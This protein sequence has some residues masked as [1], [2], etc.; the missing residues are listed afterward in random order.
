MTNILFTIII[1]HK[2]TPDLLK[3][4]L[5]TIPVREDVETIIVDDNSDPNIVDFN[6]FPGIE[7][8]NTVVVFDKSGKGAGN[9]RNVAL[10][11]IRDTKW[12]IFSDSDDYFTDYL[13]QAMD[14]YADT[15]YDMVYF[16]RNSVYVGT[17]KPATR[18]QKAN[19]RVDY[20]LSSGDVNI[21]RYKDLAPVCKFVSYKLV[22]DNNIRF[23]SIPV[24]NDAMFFL[25]VGCRSNSIKID[26]HPIYVVTEREG[27]LMKTYNKTAIE[28]RYHTST[29][30]I[31]L[32]QKYGVERYHPNLFAYIYAFTKINKGLAFKYFFISL[33]YTPVKY[34]NRDLQACFRAFLKGNNKQI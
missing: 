34:W 3:K 26:S 33:H 22:K 10:D 13:P 1:P 25:N 6:H 27:S 24:S 12:L 23:E 30:V 5:E 7:R 29:R 32:Q 4:C 2:N 19:S 11:Q 28:C 31:A 21:I 20:A 8:Q 18:H 16:K 17:D 14:E 15:D 9:A